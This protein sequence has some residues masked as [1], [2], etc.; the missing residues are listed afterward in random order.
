MNALTYSTPPRSRVAAARRCPFC[1]TPLDGGPVRYRCEPCGKA[2]MAADLD[3]EYHPA[4]G[5]TADRSAESLGANAL[6]PNPA[7]TFPDGR[8]AA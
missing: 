3:T 7:R 6:D 2:L 5:P 4:T 1:R 8:H